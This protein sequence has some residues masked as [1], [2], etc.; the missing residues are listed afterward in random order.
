MHIIPQVLAAMPTPV[1]VSDIYNP[2]RN[3]PVAGNTVNL[4]YILSGG[5]RFNLITFA[6][7]VIGLM[8]FFNIIIAGWEFLLSTGDPKK[9]ASATTRFMNGFYGLIMVSTAYL[10]IRLVTTMIGLP[11][12]L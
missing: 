8:F 3:I 5:G 4:S 6:F 12:L 9:F 1:P 11:N 2:A 10:I 7:V